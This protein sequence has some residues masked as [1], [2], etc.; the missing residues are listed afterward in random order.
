MEPASLVATYR[1]AGSGIA[2]FPFAATDGPPPAFL[3]WVAVW[4]AG[5]IGLTLWSFRRREI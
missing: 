4:F 1:A 2:A 3:V 5:M